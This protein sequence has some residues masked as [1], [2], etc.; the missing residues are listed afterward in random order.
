MIITSKYFGP[1][2]SRG[3]HVK[4]YSGAN[5]T[6]RFAWDHALSPEKN[7]EAAALNHFHAVMGKDAPKRFNIRSYTLPDASNHAMVHI[8]IEAGRS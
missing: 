8:I 6:K 5:T 3:S 7:H 1:T 2:D 4:T